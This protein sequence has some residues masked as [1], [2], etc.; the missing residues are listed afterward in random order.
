[1]DRRAALADALA[2]VL[3]ASRASGVELCLTGGVAAA[4]HGAGAWRDERVLSLDLDFLVADDATTLDALSRRWGRA[5]AEDLHKPIFKSH[6]LATETGG[7]GLDFIARSRIVIDDGAITVRM[8]PSV[9]RHVVAARFVGHDV[10]VVPAALLTLQ[11][12]VA[13]R[14]ATVGK[15]D[16]LDAQAMIDAGAVDGALLRD[17]MEELTAPDGA[18]ELSALRSRVKGSLDA[19]RGPRIRSLLAAIDERRVGGT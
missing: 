2:V 19:L 10:R 12:L 9:A 16:L 7:V 4:V 17:F 1:V 8:S 6:K 15:Y 3:D 13:R 14:G 11:K 5:F 18:I